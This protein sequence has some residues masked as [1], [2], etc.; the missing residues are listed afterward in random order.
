VEDLYA[1]A[2]V[3]AAAEGFDWDEDAFMNVGLATARQA[4]G[5]GFRFI[6][7][8]AERAVVYKEGHVFKIPLTDAES[9]PGG[10]P[11]EAHLWATAPRHVRRHLAPVLE[12]GQQILVMPHLSGVSVRDHAWAALLFSLE[13]VDAFFTAEEVPWR[14]QW[15][16]TS[17]GRYLLLD[18]GFKW[19]W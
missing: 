16:R 6:G 7:T 5:V 11:W 10:N 2:A 18:Y 14:D 19:A 9:I 12:Y 1:A 15:G 17:D 13:S 3:E 4:G 8:G